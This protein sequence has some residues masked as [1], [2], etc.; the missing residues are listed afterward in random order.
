MSRNVVTTIKEQAQALRAGLIGGYVSI[1]DVVAWADALI[2]EDHGRDVPQLFDVALLHSV[3]VGQ[4][5]SLLGEV[6]GEWNP[7]RVGRSVAK[8]VYAGVLS[9]KLSERQAAT[10]LLVA[11]REGLSPDPE[12]E[13]MAYHFDDGVDLALQ[14]TYG[15][16]ADLRAE[17]LEYLARA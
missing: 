4:A 11:V 3:D 17:M 5:V 12:F 13:N 1:P 9:G 15:S 10:A 2:G 14:G 6:P 16:L 7:G 8:L